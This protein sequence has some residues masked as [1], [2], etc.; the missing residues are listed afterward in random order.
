VKTIRTGY[1]LISLLILGLY[2]LPTQGASASAD[3]Y[4]FNILL[5]GENIGRHRLEINQ[6]D[7]YQ[8][9]K[10]SA[11]MEV[12]VLFIP[13]YR[14]QHDNTELWD[15]DCLQSINAVTDDNGEAFLVNGKYQ[16]DGF[17]L[18]TASAETML[19]GCVRSFAYWD[20]KLLKAGKLLNSQT[21]DYLPVS[22]Q[23]MGTELITLGA[24]ELQAKHV[25]LTTDQDVIDLWYSQDDRWI[26]LQSKT[27]SGRILRYELLEASRDA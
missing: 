10:I 13:L 24:N 25:Q 22:V 19:N 5:D 7:N 17:R 3:S 21:G 14:Y 27:R 18:K 16:A 12:K 4:V 11:Q 23:Q 26:A 15:Q 1:F 8:Q 2:F 20:Q 6:Q 9:I